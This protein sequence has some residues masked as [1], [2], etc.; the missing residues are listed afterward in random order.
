[1]KLGFLEYVFKLDICIQKTQ[2]SQGISNLDNK[3]RKRL[4]L[5]KNKLY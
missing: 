2:S 5:E 4:S 1:M 3:I